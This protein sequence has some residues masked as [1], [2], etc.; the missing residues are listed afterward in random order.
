MGISALGAAPEA[1]LR[2][3]GIGKADDFVSP[4]VFVCYL[5]WSSF[6]LNVT[7]SNLNLMRQSLDTPVVTLC[8]Q[9]F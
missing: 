4:V 8:N 5:R 3:I 7:W 2:H 1:L 6:K 9:S